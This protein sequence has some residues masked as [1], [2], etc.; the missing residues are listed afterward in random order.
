MLSLAVALVVVEGASVGA[1]RAQEEEEPAQDAPEPAPPARGPDDLRPVPDYDGLPEPGPPPEEVALW[2][3]R[4]VLSPLW[5]VTEWVIRRPL[6]ELLT[7]AERERWPQLFTNFFTWDDLRAGII[8]TPFVDFGLLPSIGLYFFWNDVGA[9]GHQLRAN[10]AFG[11]VDLQRGTVRDRVLLAPGVEFSTRFDAWRRP[12]WPFQGIGYATSQSNRARYRRDSLD[13][14][15]DLVLR[16][17][18]RSSVVVLAGVRAMELDPDG[19]GGD[20]PSLAAS[21]A[22]GSMNELP[23][24]FTGFV[25]YRQRVVATLDT[26]DETPGGGHG[27]RVDALGEQ[28]FDLSVP[29]DRSWVRYGG[30]IAGFLDAGADR[31]FSLH[32]RAAFVDPLGTEPVPFTELVTL[33]GNVL[34][35]PGYL[36]GS[37]VD[38]SAVVATAR[39]RWPVWVWLDASLFLASGNVFDEHLRDFAFERLRLSWGLILQSLGDRDAGFR[40]GLGFGTRALDQG[41]DV[42]SVRFTIGGTLGF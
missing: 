9:P 22:G 31:V 8:P 21:V 33:G 36:P 42:E 15:V 41:G 40:A 25:A 29:R 7:L 37:V 20:E 24:G 3:P 14:S 12:D 35:M 5:L 39:Y 19:Y 23:P 32:A 13:A 38:R 17:W 6:G 1:A 26:R 27:L 2:L 30:A 34:D 16:P 18:R 4:A 11:G 28:G 10:V